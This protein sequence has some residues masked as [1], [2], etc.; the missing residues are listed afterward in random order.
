[1]NDTSNLLNHEEV[2]PPK[3]Y[4]KPLIVTTLLGL[5][6]IS[7]LAMY[8]HHSQT[9]QASDEAFREYLQFIAKYQKT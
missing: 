7:S 9:L 4:S 5:I 6:S 2:A 8:C 1:M 3:V